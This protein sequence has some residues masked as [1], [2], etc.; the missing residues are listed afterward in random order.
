MNDANS[1]NSNNNSNNGNNNS[2]ARISNQNQKQS[3]NDASG[4]ASSLEQRSKCSN[5]SKCA[6]GKVRGRHRNTRGAI[7]LAF[8]RVKICIDL[9]VEARGNCSR[10]RGGNLVYLVNLS[11][12]GR[13]CRKLGWIGLGRKSG[14]QGAEWALDKL[15]GDFDAVG[16]EV[17]EELWLDCRGCGQHRAS[18]RFDAIWLG[19]VDAGWQD[20]VGSSNACNGGKNCQCSVELHFLTFSGSKRVVVSN[21][22]GDKGKSAR[23]CVSECVQVESVRNGT[24]KANLRGLLICILLQE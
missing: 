21:L 14:R 23:G 4:V 15:L 20:F 9:R 12:L 2:S 22:G 19:W 11:H 18:V 13:Q 16:R 6:S 3:Q 24:R 1:N 17:L 5:A 10:V 7:A 8:A